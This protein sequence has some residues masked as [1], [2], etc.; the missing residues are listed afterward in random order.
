M[1]SMLRMVAM[2]WKDEGRLLGQVRLDAVPMRNPLS[3]ACAEWNALQIIR[4]DGKVAIVTGRGAGW[5]PTTEAV[6][7][8]LIELR[9]TKYQARR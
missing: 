6:G 8:D 3:R 2:A 4:T 5:W 1:G 9:Y 7:A